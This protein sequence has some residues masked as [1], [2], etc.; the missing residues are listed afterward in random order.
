MVTT[1]YSQH[2]SGRIPFS[3]QL[4]GFDPSSYMGN[5]LLCGKPLQKCA[6]DE[7][8]TINGRNISHQEEHGHD[9]FYLGLCINVVLGFIVGFWGVCGS[10]VVKRSW[11]HALFRFFDDIKDK[12]Y[13]IVAVKLVRL[14]RKP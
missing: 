8:P 6:G 4:Q 10:L 9:N 7:P 2:L 1:S 5:P 11:R 13:V 12:I 3:T 14:S